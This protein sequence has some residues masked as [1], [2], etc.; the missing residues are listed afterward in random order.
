MNTS[1]VRQFYALMKPRVIQLIV[2]C[3]IIGMVLAVPGV[4]TLEDVRTGAIASFGIW[5]VAGAPN[6]PNQS[7]G[8]PTRCCCGAGC[9][10]DA[11]CP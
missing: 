4:P 8:N 2:F 1:V 7:A 6:R 5:L 11:G 10:G 3:A 9:A